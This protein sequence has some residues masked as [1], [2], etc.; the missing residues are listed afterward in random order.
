MPVS[1]LF[2]VFANYFASSPTPGPQ[3]FPS[4]RAPSLCLRDLHE[5]L[6]TWASCCTKSSLTT[7]SSSLVPWAERQGTRGSDT[8]EGLVPVV[9]TENT[10][11][12]PGA[13]VSR[14][15]D[16]QQPLSRDHI[17][18]FVGNHSPS[19]GFSL[20]P[21]SWDQKRSPGNN[22]G[23]SRSPLPEEARPCTENTSR[24]GPLPQVLAQPTT[25]PTRSQRSACVPSG[26]GSHEFNNQDLRPGPSDLSSDA[27]KAPNPL[28]LHQPFTAPGT[29]PRPSAHRTL[30]GTGD[31][32]QKKQ[33][34]GLITYTA[35]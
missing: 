35:S 12:T 22:Q 19:T 29:P 18:Y 2:P 3:P 24:A 7:S 25:P 14:S 6:F 27:V 15:S 33:S 1:Q 21:W 17:N 34:G 13:R 8:R 16:L 30:A 31:S 23:P 11:K 5:G 20:H 10:G 9:G 28:V 32:Q 4:L 26:R